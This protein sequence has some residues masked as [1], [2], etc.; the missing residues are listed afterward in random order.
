MAASY[1]FAMSAASDPITFAPPALWQIAQSFIVTFFGLFGTPERIAE[2]HTL[3]EKPYRLMLS[4]LRAGEA[5]MRRLL[6]IEAS[7]YAKPNVRPLLR[8]RRA[9]ARKPMSFYAHQPE[10]W[11]VSFR[12]FVSERRGPRKPRAKRPRKPRLSREERWCADYWPRP[13]FHS[14]WPLA[15]RAEALLRA[16]NNPEPYARR[17]A[18]RLH[19]TPHRAASLLRHRQDTPGLIGRERFAEIGPPAESAVK[20]FEPG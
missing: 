13:T 19:A 12:A 5:L 1:A 3:T 4:W 18:C 9:R 17:L 8:E 11:R 16:F 20:R 2:M 14:A 15:E 6:L 7:H 10:A